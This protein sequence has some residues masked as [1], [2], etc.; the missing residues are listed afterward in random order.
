MRNVRDSSHSCVQEMKKEAVRNFRL[1]DLM[2]VS[3]EEVKEI[4]AESSGFTKPPQLPLHWSDLPG[5]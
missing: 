2:S 1:V 4:L 5:G 3:G